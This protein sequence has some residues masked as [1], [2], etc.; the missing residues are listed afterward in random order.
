[1]A[2]QD[3][4]ERCSN[5]LT[6]AF[7]KL[8]ATV[9]AKDV[10]RMTDLIIQPSTGPRRCFHTPAHLF[11]VAGEE[12]P[13]EMLAGLFHDLVYVQVDLSV[14]LCFSGHVSALV[15]NKDDVLQ[16]REAGSISNGDH[17]FLVMD[18]FGFEPGRKLE[19]FGGQNEFLSAL[20]ADG[21]LGPFLTRADLARVITCIEITIPFRKD[22]DQGVS[23]AEQLYS[24]LARANEAHKL[25]L[26]SEQMAD[27][28]ASAVRLANRDISG[29]G[30]TYQVFMDNTWSLL[31]ETN[32]YFSSPNATR[33]LSI[34]SR[35]KR[36]RD[37][38]ASSIQGPFFRSSGGRPRTG[39]WPQPWTARASTWRWG[40]CT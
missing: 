34:G 16:I 8:G 19:P 9:P 32:H 14:F 13:I 30:D 35:C 21:V 12:D 1:M 23:A 39:A 17:S 26:S 38:L 4:Q 20:V 37:S 29:F 31:P 7:A 36:Y 28:L 22:S 40:G 25:G 24:R 10:E 27:T 6:R 18:L 5:L 11:N 2:E 15:K 33:F 3:Y